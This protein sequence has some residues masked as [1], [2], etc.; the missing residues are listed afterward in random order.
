MISRESSR[1]DNF[2]M[3]VA[4]RVAELSYCKRKKVGAVIVKNNNIISFG[5]NGTLP[6]DDNCCEILN[7]TTTQTKQD[8]VHAE[9]NAIL[10]LAGSVQSA[11]GSTLYL[12]LTPC[13]ECSKMIIMS[14]ILRVVYDEDYYNPYGRHKLESHDIKVDQLKRNIT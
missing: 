5:Y 6:G 1:F 7:G 10:K 11:R 3:D 9:S 14:G 4:R 2:Y 12:T 8:V 13:L